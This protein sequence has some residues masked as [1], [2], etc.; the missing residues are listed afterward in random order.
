V[1]AG[2][3]GRDDAGT[4]TLLKISAAAS[5]VKSVA[6]QVLRQV[7]GASAVGSASGHGK[8]GDVVTAR[9]GGQGSIG[10][11]LKNARNIRAFWEAGDHIFTS[12]FG[13]VRNESLI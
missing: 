3:G 9:V 11:H 6:G 2:V 1:T 4:S 5:E 10:T 12:H 8:S 13:G 7:G